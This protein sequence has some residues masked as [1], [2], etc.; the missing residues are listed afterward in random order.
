MDWQAI[1]PN[2]AP[3]VR[4]T[5]N[6]EQRFVFEGL[7]AQFW[8]AILISLPQNESFPFNIFC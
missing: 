1:N 8:K 7:L 4:I 6:G 2:I 3:I 5:K